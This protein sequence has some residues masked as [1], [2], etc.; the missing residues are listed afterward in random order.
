M[1]SSPQNRLDN[2]ADYIKLLSSCNFPYSYFVSTC[3]LSKM[4]WKILLPNIKF[5]N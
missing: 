5:L 1:K 3:S 2:P 4:L